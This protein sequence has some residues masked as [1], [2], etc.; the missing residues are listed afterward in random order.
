M[1]DWIG[2]RWLIERYALTVTQALPVET[3]IGGTR[4]RVLDGRTEQRTVQELLRPDSTV[5]GHLTFALKHEG[6]HLETLSRLFAVL[7]AA[8]LEGWIRAEPTGQYARRT[9]FLYESLTGQQLDVPDST[10][11]NYIA[12]LDPT[13]ELTAPSPINNARWRVRDN[14]LGDTS[15]S[16][17]VYLTPQVTQA[18][19]FDVGERV[20]RL[21]EQFSR[22]LVVRSAVW[23]TVKESRASFA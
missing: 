3:A 8:D 5:A 17:Q 11:G 23:L 4:A 16:P 20:A 9:G 7:P 6:V 1:P 21:E 15:F 10:R 14:L 12:A 18:L 22:E 19:A 2:Y 13:R